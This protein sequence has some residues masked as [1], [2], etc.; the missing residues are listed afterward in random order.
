MS[1]RCRE[2]HLSLSGDPV[3]IVAGRSNNEDMSPPSQLSSDW[4]PSLYMRF[5]DERMLAARDLLAR[6]PLASAGVVYDL[7][8]GPGNSAELL[9]RR[10]L[11]AEITGLDTSDSMLAHARARLPR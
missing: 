1:R 8:C 5:E 3:E 9:S 2:P 7:G 6:V 10:F 4:N 11:E